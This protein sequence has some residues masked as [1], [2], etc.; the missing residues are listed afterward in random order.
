MISDNRRQSGTADPDAVECGGTV[1]NIIFSN[2]DNGYT[3]CEISSED[4]GSL[5]TCC[6][7]MPFLQAGDSVKIRG[8]WTSHPV[9]GPQISVDYYEKA[10][11]VGSEQILAYLSSRTVR[12][13]GPKT[14]ERIVEKFGD[15]TFEVIEKHPEW[16]TDV[17]G[18]TEKR[19]RQIA[20][21]Y[22][23]NFG[24]RTVIMFCRDYFGPSLAM[25]VYK[26]WGSAA[27]D[28]VKSDPY[29][30]CDVDGIS[31]ETAD[32]MAA[33]LGFPAD[34]GN[35]VDAGIAD[36]LNENAFSNGHTMLPRSRLAAAASDRL[37]VSP[38][39]IEAS[40]GRLKNLGKITELSFDG[41]R[42]VYLTKYYDAEMGVASKLVRLKKQCAGLSERD[43]ELFIRQLEIEFDIT[44]ADAQKQAIRD[45]TASGVMV[46][47]GGPGTGKTTI[48][49]AILTIFGR[50]GFS[51]ALAAP[52]GRAAKRLSEATSE[53]AKTVHRLLETEF[54][55]G[56]ESV[57]HRN[58]NDML[59][60]DVIIVDEASMIDILLADALLKAVKPGSRVIFVGD[61]DQLPSVG[62][63]NF[64]NDVIRSGVFPVVS[65]HEI[66]RQA[67]ESL[68]VRNAHAVNEGRLPELTCR[69]GDFFFLPKNGE[70]EIAETVRSLVT[71]RLP[72]AY[73]EG[74]KTRIQVITPVHKGL[75][76]TDELN[77]RLQ[78]CL[79]PPGKGKGEKKFRNIVF[80]TGDK[81]MQTKND[82]ELRWIKNGFEE[83][84]GIFNGDIGYINGIDSDGETLEIDF[85]GRI[86]DYPF[87]SLE[88]LE[89]AYAITVH[90]SQGCEF[91][92]IVMPV[93]G[94]YPGLFTRNLLYT[95]ITRACEMVVMVG[96][97]QDVKRMVEN[98]R[99]SVRYTGLKILISALNGGP[100][101]IQ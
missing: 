31:F 77:R 6:G 27:V 91:P 16:L 98:N 76:G 79:N 26:K 30:L 4:D 11:P 28:I 55:R 82:Y 73:G 12:G 37:A 94:S 86:V 56:S 62:A 96:R 100:D 36:I 53:E 90:K 32:R 33:G 87:D 45:A 22:A 70:E 84:S 97:E 50:M 40:L 44:Y 78:E 83:G 51:I 35:R 95:A 24:A 21:S 20:D 7:T 38:E 41:N 88:E 60:E 68:I 85:D 15:Q 81:V 19:A 66:F 99:Q 101:E 46:L 9:Y 71:S 5:I 63:G 64:L 65:L 39:C 29:L 34:A 8:R 61:S 2:D 25:K 10:V 92:V 89:H 69:N 74:I 59:D 49:R 43:A 80:R 54:V 1:E 42:A 18:I 3:V 14:A 13:V 72:A 75:S 47:T 58:E 67:R 17:R 23:E 93:Y 52:T 57:F 48:V